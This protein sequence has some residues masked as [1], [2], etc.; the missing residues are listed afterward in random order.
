MQRLFE[1]TPYRELAA[2]V[3]R[4]EREFI[5]MQLLG[6]GGF[7]AVYKARHR[8]DGMEYAIKKVRLKPRALNEMERE[9]EK[10]LREVTCLARLAHPNIVRYYGAWIQA[11]PV[12]YFPPPRRLQPA[13][14]PGR[15]HPP[16]TPYE[17]TWSS[18]ADSTQGDSHNSPP[19]TSNSHSSSP[20]TPKAQDSL[21]LKMRY[22]TEDV[23]FES[24]I[25]DDETK[26]GS[27]ALGPISIKGHTNHS[28]E[29][30]V[31]FEPL[32]ES[33]KGPEQSSTP[34]LAHVTS[35]LSLHTLPPSPQLP[36]LSQTIEEQPLLRTRSAAVEG[37]VREVAS[38]IGRSRSVGQLHTL[39][40]QKQHRLA[41]VPRSPPPQKM[42]PK[43][44]YTGPGAA[45]DAHLSWELILYIQMELCEEATLH[46]WLQARNR[47]NPTSRETI[48]SLFEQLLAAVAHV[49]SQRIVH[50][51]L[52]PSNVFLSSGGVI[53]LGDFGL[54]KSLALATVLSHSSST[55][56][57]SG[58]TSSSPAGSFAKTNTRSKHTRGLGTPAYSAPEQE[59]GRPVTD[60]T[61]MFS[62]GILLAEMC[63]VART[64][65]ERAKVLSD[66]RRRILSPSVLANLPVEAATILWLT[67]S[68]PDDRPTAVQ[69]LD[70]LKRAFVRS[71]CPACGALNPTASPSASMSSFSS[72]SSP[73]S[74]PP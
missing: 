51:D 72:I 40:Y 61:D 25:E 22:R 41:I 29:T 53:K 17:N 11:T 15:S 33:E 59:N 6:R 31:P 2:N 32:Q 60:K 34:S 7:G 47:M 14:V 49:H 1:F 19:P 3:G 46:D 30:T 20:L 42:G 73:N 5:E 8:L 68:N 71:V 16:S 67:Q 63:C 38:A 58:S 45:S 64:S 44:G 27:D 50:R 24:K 9:L 39:S 55:S 21:R 52:K 28:S 56:C 26:G 12:P 48:T 70:H 54:A 69:C 10:V 66:V 37:G 23:I 4:Y 57:H 13:P 62:L 36:A 18:A 35:A 74:P 65:M 43:S